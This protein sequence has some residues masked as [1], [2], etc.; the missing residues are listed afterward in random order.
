[1]KLIEIVFDGV[2]YLIEEGSNLVKE[3]DKHGIHIAAPCYR[4]TKQLGCCKACIVEINN[5]KA[6]AC[7]SKIQNGMSIIYDTEELKV[8]RRKAVE[9]YVNDPNPGEC[10]GGSSCGC[11]SE[12]EESCC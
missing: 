6:Y 11:G 9:A 4:N 1:M 2:K 5:E 10:C 8:E 7:C 3:M 12:S